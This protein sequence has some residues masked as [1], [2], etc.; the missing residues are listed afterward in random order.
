MVVF[1]DAAGIGIL[2]PIL[3]TLI[4]NPSVDFLPSSVVISQRHFYYGLVIAI[5]FLC[6]FSGATLISKASDELGRKKALMICLIGIFIGYGLTAL[7]IYLKSMALLILGR[8]IGGLTAA[9]QPVAQAAI[10]DLSTTETKT[11]NLGL[12]MFAFSLGLVAG[13]LMGGLLSNSQICRYFTNATPFYAILI[14]TLINIYF[15]RYFTEKRQFQGH[16]QFNLKTII[17]QFIPMFQIKP[18]RRLSL[19]F[20]IMQF[21]FNTFYVFIPVFLFQRYGFNTLQNSMMMLVLGLSMALSTR[22]LIAIVQRFLN[23]KQTVACGLIVMAIS[24]FL[25]LIIKNPIFSYLLAV[26]LMLAFGLAY[27]SMLA[28]FSHSVDQTQQGW[29]M[30]ITVSLFTSGAALTSILGGSIMAIATDAPMIVALIGFCISFAF[31]VIPRNHT[32]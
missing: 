5:F 8:I 28:L 22:F 31:V 6:W 4:M 16:F 30:G 9:S 15:M 21:A 19:I 7:S 12:I 20:F 11:K 17:T 10:I 2:F 29:V 18:V 25:L 32:K 27:T 14:I 24:I 23:D 1:I 3:N 26:P 13:P